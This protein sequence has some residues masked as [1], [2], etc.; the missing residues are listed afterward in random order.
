MERE[1]P[2]LVVG[3]GN[4]GARYRDTRHNVG[5]LVVEE[6]A[7]RLGWTFRPGAGP[8][9]EASAPGG[10]GPFVL[11]EPLTY[12]NLSGQA[13]AGWARQRGWNVDAPPPSPPAPP[14]P[15]P[16]SAQAFAGTSQPGDAGMPA[17]PPAPPAVPAEPAPAATPWQP[18]WRPL[19]IADD[20]ALPLGALRLRARG[21]S[22]GQKGLASVSAE[23]GHD[24]FPRLRLGIA[25]SG[26]TVAPADW[27]EF[28]LA[29][30]AADELPAVEDLVA[31][32]AD[33]VV[34]CREHGV[35]VAASRFNRR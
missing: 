14:P 23:L 33:A 7:R 11:L 2:L 30:F 27:P 10:D 29:P 16:P 22:G 35:E 8:W 19:V 25:P 18:S 21:S 15:S 5:F 17:S 31:R 13:V 4:P 20:L 12:M 26:R 1:A 24:D 32:A 9:R 28:V 3:L 6:L 34:S